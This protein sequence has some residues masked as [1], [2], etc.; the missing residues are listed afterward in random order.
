MTLFSVARGDMKSG[1]ALS[2]SRLHDSPFM[3]WVSLP[4]WR[5]HPTRPLLNISFDVRLIYY[6]NSITLKEKIEDE[7]IDPRQL[8]RALVTIDLGI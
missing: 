5:R 7:D 1:A 6:S 8:C 3:L 2:S 4:N